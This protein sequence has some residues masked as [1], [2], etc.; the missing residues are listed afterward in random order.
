MSF[1]IAESVASK[2]EIPITFQPRRKLN[3]HQYVHK[4]M[5]ETREPQIDQRLG[6]LREHF[7]SVSPRAQHNA[8][9]IEQ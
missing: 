6:Y 8:A 1:R 5:N 3:K 9:G 4:N 2:I 7:Q